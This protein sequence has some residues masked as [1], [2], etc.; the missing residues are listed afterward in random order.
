[1]NSLPPA[2]L[3]FTGRGEAFCVQSGPPVGLT[4]LD[5]AAGGQLVKSNNQC[6]WEMGQFGLWLFHLTWYVLGVSKRA[7]AASH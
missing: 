3:L 4:H 7:S 1:M 5:G 2:P 6:V